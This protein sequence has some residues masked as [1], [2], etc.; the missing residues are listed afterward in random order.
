M[1]P[2]APERVITMNFKRVNAVSGPSDAKRDTI[3]VIA[4]MVK[5]VSA[6]II[7]PCSRIVFA[8]ATAPTKEPSPDATKAIGIAAVFGISRMTKK[9]ALIKITAAVT[10][11]AVTIMVV[12]ITAAMTMVVMI[13]AVMIMVKLKY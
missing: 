13:T 1:P 3:S 7:I 10:I 2:S 8:A 6:P 9:S 11:T 4:N 5:P 12:M